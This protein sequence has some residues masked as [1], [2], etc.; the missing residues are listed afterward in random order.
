MSKVLLFSQWN[1]CSANSYVAQGIV[2]NLLEQNKQLVILGTQRNQ[3]IENPIQEQ[4]GRLHFHEIGEPIKVEEQQFNALQGIE[5]IVFQLLFYCKSYEIEEIITIGNVRDTFQIVARVSLVTD[6]TT[7]ITSYI[8][9]DS[10][11]IP[12]KDEDLQAYRTSFERIHKM[13]CTYDITILKES[14]EHLHDSPHIFSNPLRSI[15]QGRDSLESSLGIRI[16][17]HSKVYFVASGCNEH[18]TNVISA[19]E[20]VAEEYPNKFKNDNTLLF[21]LQGSTVSYKRIADSPQNLN[22]I[23]VHYHIPLNVLLDLY[24]ATNYGL[25]RGNLFTLEHSQ[26]GRQQC[27]ERDSIV[28]FILETF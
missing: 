9:G 8:R 19:F 2:N 24:D 26:R 3:W 13:Y 1:N 18:V 21:V 6:F 12:S 20:R 27:I 22:I 5:Y 10:S 16:P 7:R 4:E 17:N 14:Y 25:H 11:D 23:Y 15:Q 28:N